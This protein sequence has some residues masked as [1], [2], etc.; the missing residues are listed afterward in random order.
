V[1]SAYFIILITMLTLHFG[2]IKT[3]R[4]LFSMGFIAKNN[5]NMTGILKKIKTSQ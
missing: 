4:F 5:L 1:F 2:Q 3:A